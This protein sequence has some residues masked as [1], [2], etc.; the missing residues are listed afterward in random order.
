MSTTGLTAIA[1]RQKGYA[2]LYA[3]HPIPA[4]QYGDGGQYIIGTPTQDLGYGAVSAGLGA[5]QDSLNAVHMG[6]LQLGAAVT[7]EE[8]GGIGI[9][10]IALLGGLALIA[11]KEMSKGPKL[12]A[13]RNN[14]RRRKSRK[15]PSISIVTGKSSS[16]TVKGAQRKSSSR[17]LTER[18]RKHRE[19]VKKVMKIKREQGISLAEA[20]KLV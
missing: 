18:Q 20:W 15:K 12:K 2:G 17:T 10:G 4:G 5:I 19:R 11:Y 16:R 9:V 6:A 8:N 1:L 3:S 13:A 14:P 7:G